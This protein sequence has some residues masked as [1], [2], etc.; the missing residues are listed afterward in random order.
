MSTR[1]QVLFP[2]DEIAA[3]RNAAARERVPVATWVRRV[4]RE[5]LA[6]ERHA[7]IF[8]AGPV[9]GVLRETARR[10]Y[11][12]VPPSP[13]DLQQLEELLARLDGEDE[14]AEEA[15]D[16]EIARRL[17]ELRAG[18]ATLIPADE[19]FERIRQ[20]RRR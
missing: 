12:A 7:P 8:D 19:V 16:A 17:V 9:H 1:L 3:I 14:G 13:N 18:R 15:W 4:L 20:R 6:S 5:A 2:D 11:R 10:G